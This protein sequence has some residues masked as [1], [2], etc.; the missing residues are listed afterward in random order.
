M[1]AIETARKTDSKRRKRKRPDEMPAKAPPREAI[2]PPRPD[3][4]VD[5]EDPAG[6]RGGGIEQ[7]DEDQRQHDGVDGPAQAGG[8]DDRY[9][10]P[11]QQ[12]QEHDEDVG[13]A[14]ARRAGESQHIDL[15]IVDNQAVLVRASGC[16][17]VKRA[18]PVTSLP[19]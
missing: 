1:N 2:Q 17:F 9:R 4:V 12:Q 5:D 15:G 16:R 18:R 6:L 11:D 13:E 3:E 14:G 7:P 19:P 10:S 8:D